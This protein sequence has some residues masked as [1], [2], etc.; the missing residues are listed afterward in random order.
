LFVITREDARTYRLPPHDS[1]E[2]SVARFTALL[3]AG[4]AP[5]PLAGSLGTALIGQALADLPPGIERLVIVPDGP[6][7]R[8]PFAALALSDGRFLIERFT[9][10]TVP[11]AEIAAT[12]WQRPPRSPRS[13]IA[14]FADPRFATE[15]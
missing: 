9:I 3:E 15:S 13:H 11:A 14:V 10:S 1:L 12:L 4:A 7:H 8:L 2:T 5:R 6:L